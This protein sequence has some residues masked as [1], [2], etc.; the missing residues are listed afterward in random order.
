MAFGFGRLLGYRMEVG[1]GGFFLSGEFDL[2]YGESRVIGNIQEEGSA[3]GSNQLGESWFEDWNFE[4][5]VSY[6]LALK[7]GGSPGMLKAWKVD[8]YAL[9]GFRRT[10]T[11]FD[12]YYS[13]C[14][15]PEPCVVGDYD[16]GRTNRDSHYTAWTAGVGVE[17]IIWKNIALGVEG[18]YTGYKKE[19]W[20]TSFRDLGVE[21]ASES[22]SQEVGLS[23]NLM[24]YL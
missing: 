2:E 21:V 19:K 17:K 22:G 5:E 13:G 24:C 1:E 3:E 16:S 18:S 15:K 9:A 23:L 10:Q 6:G 11:R 8:V 14:F 4:K 7:L 12:T 20:V